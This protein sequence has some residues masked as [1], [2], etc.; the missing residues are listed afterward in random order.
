MPWISLLVSP[1]MSLSLCDRPLPLPRWSLPCPLG[2]AP[3]VGVLAWMGAVGLSEN[4]QH[5]WAG[6]LCAC[7]PLWVG[8]QVECLQEGS[9][10]CHGAVCIKWF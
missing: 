7:W 4:G 6:I 8:G 5:S 1:F 3:I 10:L 9:T 2:G